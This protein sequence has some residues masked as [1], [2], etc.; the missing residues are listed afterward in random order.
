MVNLNPK[1]YW[2][3]SGSKLPAGS[4]QYRYNGI[5]ISQRLKSREGS[6]FEQAICLV[7]IP[8]G[9]WSIQGRMRNEECA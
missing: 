8:V 5:G 6:D 1:R 7:R 4:G 3:P 2:N 9:R